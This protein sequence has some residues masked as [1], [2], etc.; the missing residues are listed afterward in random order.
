MPKSQTPSPSQREA[1]T[2]PP[3]TLLVLAG[4]GAGKTF[5]LIERIR[6]LIDELEIDPARICAFTYTNKAAGEIGT[7]LREELGVAA[8]RVKRGTMHA[9]CA[10]LLR[11][12][13]GGAGVA[14][15]FGIAD[16]RYQLEVLRR[17]QP[18]QQRWHGKT[19]NRFSAHRVRGDP[20]RTDEL[21]LLE[22]YERYLADHNQLDFDTIIIRAADVLRSSAR[23][24]IRNQWDVVLVDEFQDLNPLQYGIVR[25]LVGV[26]G[27]LFAVGDDEQSVFA[28]NGADPRVFQHL[29]DDCPSAR[30]VYLCE[31]YRCARQIFAVARRLVS[32]N[33]TLFADRI[34]PVAERES[35][36]PVEAYTF[37]SEAEETRWL[38]SDILRDRARDG[39]DLSEFAILYRRH[40]IAEGIETGFINAGIPCRL[41][42]GRAFAEDRI[43]AH[44]VAALRAIA[45][46]DDDV[47]RDAFFAAML[48]KTLFQE[49]RAKAESRRSGSAAAGRQDSAQSPPRDLR[50]ELNHELGL[51]PQGDAGARHIRRALG[52]WKNLGAL[53]KKHFS[54]EAL[55]LEILSGRVGEYKTVLEERHEDIT[56]PASHPEVIRLAGRLNAA[57]GSGRRIWIARQGGA[58]IALKGMLAVAGYSNINIGD[59]APEGAELVHPNDTP[60]LGASLGLFKAMQLNCVTGFSESFR[61]FTVIDLET[62]D[63]DAAT[64]EVVEVAAARVREGR[65]VDEFRQLVKPYGPINS[66]A[67]AIH[68]IGVSDVAAAD[69]FEAVWPKLR[70]FCGEDIL[71]AHN[72]YEFDFLILRRLARSTPFPFRSTTFDTLP[73][74]RDL[75]AASRRLEDLAA[76]FGIDPGRSHGALDDTRTL[77]EVFPR[78]RELQA[79]RERK[80]C[81]ADALDYLGLALWLSGDP[82]CPEA[83]LLRSLL[84]IY[85]FR[86]YSPCL[87]YYEREQGGDESIPTADEVIEL[88]GGRALL[89]KIREE[90]SIDERYPATM[91]RLRALLAAIPA[92]SLEEQIRDF[93]ARAALSKFS[94]EEPEAG[95]VNLLTLHA[96]KGL[97]FS[98]VY[99]VGVEDSE[100]LGA[101]GKPASPPEVAENRRLVYVGM[102]RAKDRLVLTRVKARGGNAT[103]GHQFMDELGIAPRS[104]VELSEV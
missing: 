7:R 83:D 48:P 53:G 28:W 26:S 60:T 50:H 54:L 70:A 73:L 72:G 32:N 96:T 99:I 56:D 1:I 57:R 49:L 2:A 81:L 35:P 6:F 59:V 61:D 90:R 64:A 33:P 25:E 5:C 27:H 91:Q 20:L 23:E 87:E 41:A 79:Q 19:L 82:L 16:E 55:A 63:S 100:F 78:L 9:F 24:G 94:G 68:K 102:T 58:E 13:G 10:D 85:P 69:R 40:A 51:R 98:R 66:A 34:V 8:E 86:R 39:H 88:L 18:G 52:A 84:R 4:P 45:F 29:L 21:A 46:P 103:G 71:V 80:T 95:R 75:L 14:P 31:N 37:D 93:L 38:V 30:K 12:F 43:V 42:L 17:F 11:R 74:A 62:T 97:E 15:G 92:G 44:L 65:I 22:R 67:T 101:P 36:F 104:A 89:A 3:G 77:A 76:R 47:H